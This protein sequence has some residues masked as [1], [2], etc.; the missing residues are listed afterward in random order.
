MFE[1]PQIFLTTIFFNFF[2]KQTSKLAFWDLVNIKR[3]KVRN[4]GYGSPDLV[5]AADRFMV[6]GP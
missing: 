4:F 5:T 3:N 2:E 6:G 1:N